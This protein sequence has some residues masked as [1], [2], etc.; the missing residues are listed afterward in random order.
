MFYPSHSIRSIKEVTLFLKFIF[1][2]P[3]IQKF[4]MYSCS[5]FYPR[6]AM[7]SEERKRKTSLPGAAVKARKPLDFTRP[8]SSPKELFLWG[9]GG[10]NT[11]IRLRKNDIEAFRSKFSAISESFLVDHFK[12]SNYCL[13]LNSM[14]YNS[15]K[16]ENIVLLYT[17]PK[18]NM[19]GGGDGNHHFLILLQL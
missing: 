17:L 1:Q 10:N 7:T 12:W 8:N 6:T 3:L 5:I 18:S 19:S 9:G 13:L 4:I 16:S 15:T 2:H 11:M 14:P